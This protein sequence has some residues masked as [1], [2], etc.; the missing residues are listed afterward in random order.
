MPPFGT[1]TSHGLSDAWFDAS[2]ASGA[3]YWWIAD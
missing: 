2:G 1:I 3:V